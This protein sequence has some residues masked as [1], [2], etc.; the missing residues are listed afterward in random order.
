M[1]SNARLAFTKHSLSRYSRCTST[2]GQAICIQVKG[3]TSA[4]PLPRKTYNGLK[5]VWILVLVGR[6]GRVTA[7]PDRF[8]QHLLIFMRLRW[9]NAGGGLVHQNFQHGIFRGSKGQGGFGVRKHI[10]LGLLFLY[11]VGEEEKVTV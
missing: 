10:D 4:P 8:E 6:N 1:A 5:D 3:H 9:L 11:S 2:E 7:L